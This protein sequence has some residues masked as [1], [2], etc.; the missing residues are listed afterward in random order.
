MQTAIG[1]IM[2]VLVSFPIG[3]FLGAVIWEIHIRREKKD[4]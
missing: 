2:G 4:K 3:M 1:F